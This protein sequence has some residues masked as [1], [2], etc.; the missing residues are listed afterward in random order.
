MRCGGEILQAGAHTG[1][2]VA[3]PRTPFLRESVN[4]APGAGFARWFAAK[5][6]KATFFR[7]V[8]TL[9]ESRAGSRH[10]APSAADIARHIAHDSQSL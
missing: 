3:A 4:A 1:A 6:G 9:G 8:A 10:K 2:N 5:V 7:K